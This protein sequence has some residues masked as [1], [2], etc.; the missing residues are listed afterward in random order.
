M[1]D[2][3]SPPAGDSEMISQMEPLN[4][5][6]MKIAARSVWMAVGAS[7]RSATV[8]M[9]VSRVRARN[10]TLPER[11]SLST[12]PSDPFNNRGQLYSLCIAFSTGNNTSIAWGRF[13][14]NTTAV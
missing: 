1:F 9:V 13:C 5:N 3:F 11:R 14:G 4:S 10:L 2:I 6:E 12:F 8:G 7:A